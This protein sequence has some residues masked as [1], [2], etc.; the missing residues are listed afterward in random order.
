MSGNSELQS[1]AERLRRTRESKKLKQ[2]DWCR[3]VGIGPQAWNN[4]ER[5][6]N[7]ISIDQAIKVCAATGVSLDWIYR[8]ITAGLPYDIAVALQSRPRN[9]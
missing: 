2:A 6:I 3:F 5:G 7:R 8:G 1:L 4:Y 9:D